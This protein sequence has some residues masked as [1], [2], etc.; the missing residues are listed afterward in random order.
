MEPLTLSQ[1]ATFAGGTIESGSADTK[2]SRISTDSRTLQSGDLFV[3]LRGPTFD[4]HKF[5]VQAA[6]RGASGAL[7]DQKWNGEAPAGFA[8]IRVRDTL[9]AYQLLAANY[10]KTLPLKV[11][12][13]TGSNGKTS[14]KDFVAAALGK[15]FRVT[16]TEGNF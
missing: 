1:V 11:I 12:A 6:E 5:I 9:A 2:I 15:K 16:K 14:T 13:I 7:A 3:P 4:G 8:L 10:R